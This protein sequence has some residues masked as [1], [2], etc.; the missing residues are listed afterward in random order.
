[1]IRSARR[2]PLWL[3]VVAL[4]V[5]GVIF[6]SA[7]STDESDDSVDAS[8][9]N[10]D[11][12]TNAESSDDQGDGD[13]NSDAAMSSAYG[14]RITGTDGTSISVKGDLDFG[15]IG[16]QPLDLQPQLKDGVTWL[17]F[18]SAAVGGDISFTVGEGGPVTIEIIY[19]PMVEFGAELSDLDDFEVITTAA[20]ISNETVDITF[21]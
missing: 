4:T 11:A 2:S 15:Q 19:G 17:L 18:N 5:L 1:M 3:A 14:Y 20:N 9:Q 12:T 6:G 13:S 16:D 7:C 21:P 8:E 10:S